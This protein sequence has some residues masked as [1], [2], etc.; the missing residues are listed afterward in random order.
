MAELCYRH[1]RK[2]Q[3]SSPEIELRFS[4][5]ANLL[6]RDQNRVQHNQYNVIDAIALESQVMLITQR[7]RERL[8]VKSASHALEEPLRIIVD[9][10]NE[11]FKKKALLLRLEISDVDLFHVANDI[12]EDSTARSLIRREPLERRPAQRLLILPFLPERRRSGEGV[13]GGVPHCLRNEVSDWG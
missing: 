8:R 5:N 13:L 4:E 2:S 11:P 6:C 1:V 7:E 12:L 3:R 10:V 9:T